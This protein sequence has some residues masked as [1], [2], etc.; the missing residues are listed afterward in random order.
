MNKN[1][2]TESQS[3]EKLAF[4][5]DEEQYKIPVENNK[6]EDYVYRV[7]RQPYI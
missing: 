3:A 7:S 2:V 1:Q 4:I 5:L 6:T